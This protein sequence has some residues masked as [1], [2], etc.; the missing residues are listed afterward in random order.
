MQTIRIIRDEHRSLEAVLD[1]MIYFVHKIQDG[2]AKPDFSL[3]AAMI[4]YIDTVPE[5]FHHPKENEYLFRQLRLRHP[6]AAPLLDRLTSEHSAGAEKIHTL[7]Q[8]LTRYQQ[9]GTTELPNFR[10][11][12]EAYAAFH[13]EHIAAEE[14]DVLPLAE[15]YLTANDW[16]VI[17][18]A[19]L[20]HTDPMHGAEPGAR[21][22]LF[23]RIIELAPPAI[24]ALCSRWWTS[25]R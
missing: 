9:G 3:L 16:G 23:G 1:G 19:F 12:V 10:A 11:A 22:A 14:K 25:Q 15:K 24:G 4:Y 2:G 17:D 20:R 6:D 8:A 21:E 7:E 18:A 5:R 13:W